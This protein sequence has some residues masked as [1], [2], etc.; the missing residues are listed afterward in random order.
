MDAEAPKTH[1]IS[2]LRVA[3][4]ARGVRHVFVRDLVAE[5]RIGVFDHERKGRQRVRIN[6]DLEVDDASD[7]G[8]RLN[9]VVCY[10][11][12]VEGIRTILT[13]EHINLAETLAERIAEISLAD[14]RVR[15]A[16]VR[17][18]KLDVIAEAESVGVE[19]ERVRA[20]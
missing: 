20:R 10:N 7:H 12:V 14:H 1:K 19:I 15:T 13:A 9:R 2:T 5:A 18:E 3:D 4:A 8:D 16:R 17:V 11:R 6:V